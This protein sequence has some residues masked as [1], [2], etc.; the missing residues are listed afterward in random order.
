MAQPEASLPTP[1]IWNLISAKTLENLVIFQIHSQL[2]LES[3][4]EP[5]R[6]LG[7]SEMNGHSF[8]YSNSQLYS[9]WFVDSQEEESIGDFW[10]LVQHVSLEAYMPSQQ[11]N[12]QTNKNTGKSTIHLKFV[13]VV[14]SWGKPLPPNWKNSQAEKE[15]DSSP[16]RPRP[17]RD[18]LG[19]WCCEENMHCGFWRFSGD[20]SQ[21]QKLQGTQ[22]SGASTLWGV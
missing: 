5:W 17:G 15:N 4:F 7:L 13:R 14:K 16:S 21:R 22:S 2:F 19:N 6:S 10:F 8:S 18:L 20:K 9:E 11:V 3:S 12:K 1:E